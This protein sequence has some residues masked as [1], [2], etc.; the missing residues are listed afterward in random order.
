MNPAQSFILEIRAILSTHPVQ[1][2]IRIG[3]LLPLPNGA[4][5][6]VRKLLLSFP[7]PNYHR[8]NIHTIPSLALSLPFST[9]TLS[10]TGISPVFYDGGPAERRAENELACF[11]SPLL[12]V[13]S[14]VLGSFVISFCPILDATA[15]LSACVARLPEVFFLSFYLL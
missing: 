11:A 15:P 6:S 1:Y 2:V 7:S 9:I 8:P 10:N 14:L 4:L 5:R 3:P 12:L 13:W